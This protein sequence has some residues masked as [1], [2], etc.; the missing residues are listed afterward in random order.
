ME[1]S[2]QT[3]EVKVRLYNLT[4]QFVRKYQPRFYMQYRGAQED[5]A[6]DFYVQFLTEKSREEGK[7][8]SLLDKYDSTITS[9]EYLVKISV[10]R[11][12]IDRSRQDS[13]PLKSID[14]FI[15]EFGDV[16]LK[17][18]GLSTEDEDPPVDNRQFST[19]FMC[20]VAAR[21]DSLSESAKRSIQ[22]RYS[23]IRDVLCRSYRDLFDQ[24]IDLNDPLEDD[25]ITELFVYLESDAG[26]VWCPVQQLTP[27]TVCCLYHNKVLDFNRFTGV[28]RHK[29][30]DLSV[31]SS[32]LNRLAEIDVFKSGLTREQF[33]ISFAL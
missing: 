18:F 23:E 8:E 20:S 32:S 2:K 11:K 12:L 3:D 29:G 31:S 1:K 13:H 25:L 4:L 28:C 16:M 10:Q 26:R 24:V 21:F 27:K 5:L 6:A 9:L 33:A 19:E 17:S 22:K 30:I 14:H 15:D 7:E